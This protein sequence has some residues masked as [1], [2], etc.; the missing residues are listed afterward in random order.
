M[1]FGDG[2]ALFDCGVWRADW[3]FGLDAWFL[4][5]CDGVYCCDVAWVVGCLYMFWYLL[6]DG[7]GAVMVAI[8]WL[9]GAVLGCVVVVCLL[10]C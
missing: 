5:C 6:F 8:W 4:W 1:G 3:L 10:C 2:D 9:F 7:V